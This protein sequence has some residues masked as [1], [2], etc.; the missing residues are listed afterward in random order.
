M[1]DASNFLPLAEV[2]AILQ[3]ADSLEPL[4]PADAPPSNGPA[5]YYRLA[6]RNVRVGFIGAITNHDFCG[7]CNK[8]RV[9]CDGK[10][11]PCLGNHLETDLTGALRPELDHE[12]LLRLFE[13]TLG[14]KPAEHDFRGNYQPQ[15]IMT[16][17]G[18]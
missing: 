6:Q 4:D 1:L 14:K 10:L 18:G 17:L 3:T 2:R 11:R 12:A 15:R 5:Q 16:A 13:E 8:M 9:T 7:S